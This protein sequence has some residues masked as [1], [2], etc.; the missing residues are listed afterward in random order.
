MGATM[1]DFRQLAVSTVARAIG[2]VERGKRGLFHA[3]RFL[4]GFADAAFDVDE[5]RRLSPLLYD[6]SPFYRANTLFEWEREWLE[7]HLAGVHGRVLVGGCGAGREITAL[8]ERGLR[9]C[10]F[11]PSTAL[12][13]EASE[14][15][16]S[17]LLVDG[18]YGDLV[19][20]VLE[21][22]ASSP[23]AG[24]AT[25]RF[26]AILLGW[27]SFGHLLSTRERVRLLAAARVLCP[28]GPILGSYPATHPRDEARAYRLGRTV[29]GRLSG[30]APDDDGDLDF[31]PYAGY[32]ARL[33]E[34][35]LR[36]EAAA[37]GLEVR[38]HSV[39]D[40]P[41]FALVASDG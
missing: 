32:L 41:H 12:L 19:A 23:L 35:K 24:W 22:D 13:R 30:R 33:D 17:A 16:A 21:G 15:V 4:E 1:R 29:G 11:D 38:E 34:E 5:K 36:R 26:D 14:R 2:E 40:Y 7:R 10:A 39:E 6:H 9:V 3:G 31:Y 25:T 20:A 37:A 18:T 28:H 27:G 8:E